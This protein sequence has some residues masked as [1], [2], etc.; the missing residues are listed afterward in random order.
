VSPFRNIALS[1][2]DRHC[3]R[4]EGPDKE[5][6]HGLLFRILHIVGMVALALTI[7]GISTTSSSSQSSANTERRVGVLLF[8][9]LY[10]VSVGVAVMQWVNRYRLM[11]Y[12]KQV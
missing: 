12:R 9:G 7:I 2:V 1:S 3:V 6:K 10:I 5:K 11:K 8:A 4:T